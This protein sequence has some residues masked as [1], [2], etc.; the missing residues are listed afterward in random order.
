[1]ARVK[2]GVVSRRKHNKLLKLTK[3]YR[4]TKSR[5]IRVAHEAALHAGQYAYHGRKLRKRNFRTLWITRISSAVKEQGL[6]YSV[7]I[8]KLKK[9]NIVLD[10]KILSHLLVEDPKTFQKVVEVAKKA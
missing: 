3:G 6:S 9:A 5:L 2:R 7:F 1:M 4:G 8:N 10:R